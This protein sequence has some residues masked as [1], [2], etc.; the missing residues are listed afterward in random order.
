M[1]RQLRLKQDV[2]PKFGTIFL[3]LGV[4]QNDVK[5]NAVPSCWLQQKVFGR[6]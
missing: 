1:N 5:L 2:R 4:R 3:F 6:K